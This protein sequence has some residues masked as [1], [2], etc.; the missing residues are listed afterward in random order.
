MKLI[1][2]RKPYF[3][4]ALM[5]E[6][7]NIATLDIHLKDT[8]GVCFYLSKFTLLIMLQET[9]CSLTTERKAIRMNW[10]YF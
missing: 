7:E 2:R 10:L 4:A 8:T 5:I 3:V 6:R 9:I 1:E